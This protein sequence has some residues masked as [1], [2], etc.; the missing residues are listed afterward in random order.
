MFEKLPYDLQ[1]RV[2]SY[3]VLNC[4][5]DFNL[6]YRIRYLDTRLYD[7]FDNEFENL[8]YLAYLLWKQGCN[9]LIF[10]NNLAIHWLTNNR[11]NKILVL[12]YEGK[13][14]IK[15]LKQLDYLNI[16][17]TKSQKDKL[18]K[19]K[20]NLKNTLHEHIT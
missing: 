1:N 6:H 3:F 19:G 12:G 7:D 18:C 5:R 13:K 11:E 8:K 9:D 14:N 4:V 15:Y 16:E 20:L 17:I 10:E 2:W